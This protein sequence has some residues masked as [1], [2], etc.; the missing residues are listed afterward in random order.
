MQFIFSPTNLD[1]QKNYIIDLDVSDS[2][3]KKSTY[4]FSITIFDSSIKNITKKI[5]EKVPELGAKVV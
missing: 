1:A 4:T 5:T 2:F 3:D